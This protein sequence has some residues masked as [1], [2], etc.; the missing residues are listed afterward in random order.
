[1]GFLAGLMSMVGQQCWLG[2]QLRR[3]GQY[4]WL[5]GS[6]VNFPHGGVTLSSQV[7]LG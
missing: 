5:V 2:R 7:N 3:L 6:L 1:M 4:G